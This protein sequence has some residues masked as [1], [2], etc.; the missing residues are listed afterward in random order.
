MRSSCPVCGSSE[1]AERFSVGDLNQ[2]MSAE[3][4]RYLE[5]ARCGSVFVA[6]VPADLGS[7]YGS[8]YAPYKS[9][10]PAV[11]EKMVEAERPKL[12]I[13][14]S[15]ARGRALLEVGAASGA[16]AVLAQRNGFDVTAIEMDADSCSFMRTNGIAA[17]ESADVVQAV[18]ALPA[19]DVIVMWH[20]IE[21]LPNP[22]EAFRALAAKLRPGGVLVIAAPNPG[23]LEFRVF[24]RLWVHVDA[25]RHLTLIPRSALDQLARSAG[26]A[27][28]LARHRFRYDAQFDIYPWFIRSYLNWVSPSLK[29]RFVLRVATRLLS[30][31]LYAILSVLRGG[32]GATY[33]RVF[34]RER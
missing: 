30:Y 9:R 26:L 25:P 10:D 17:V 21:H 11:F 18:G 24:G 7:Y 14:S 1:I 31:P 5:C 13:V 28:A 6:D 20:A 23:S 12:E 22:A 27:P 29:S 34:A 16:F 32:E 19:F 15:V 33:T 8:G 3:V 2:H 4:F